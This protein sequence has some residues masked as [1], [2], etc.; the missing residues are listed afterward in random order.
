MSKQCKEFGCHKQQTS[1]ARSY[2][3]KLCNQHFDEW[4]DKQDWT[5]QET[6]PAC[7]PCCGQE[8]S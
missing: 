8:V 5:E 3:Q 7:C 2:G 1:S 6:T 4:F